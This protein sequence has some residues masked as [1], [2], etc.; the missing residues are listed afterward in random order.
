MRKFKDLRVGDPLV[1]VNLKNVTTLLDIVVRRD[2]DTIKLLELNS[3]EFD[4]DIPCGDDDIL[5]IND[6]LILGTDPKKV[7]AVVHQILSRE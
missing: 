3:P 4:I 1:V 7:L 2:T 6:N 5:Q